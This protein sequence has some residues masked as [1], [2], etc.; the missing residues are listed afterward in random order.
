MD[1]V[2]K[3]PVV[4]RKSWNEDYKRRIFFATFIV[5][6]PFFL[7]KHASGLN[8]TQKDQEYYA[9]ID[10][11][12]VSM[13][14]NHANNFLLCWVILGSLFN[15][16]SK[17]ARRSALLFSNPLKLTLKAR[18]HLPKSPNVRNL[19]CWNNHHLGVTL[20][21]KNMRITD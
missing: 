3:K 19:C 16:L 21:K 2:N 12:R 7:N 8:P 4:P 11:W 1:S 9:L 18:L 17:N 10:A 5:N 14:F 15:H 6:H 20:L 13:N